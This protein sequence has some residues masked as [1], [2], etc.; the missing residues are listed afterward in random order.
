L[1]LIDYSIQISTKQFKELQ[2][3][4]SVLDIS[5]PIDKT[6]A[7]DGSNWLLENEMGDETKS[8]EVCHQKWIPM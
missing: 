2:E 7:L 8:F 5:T 1:N 4:L 6:I 3:A